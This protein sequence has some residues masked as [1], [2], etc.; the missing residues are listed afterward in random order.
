[1]V[2]DD[3]YPDEFILSS[4]DC[5]PS[6]DKNGHYAINWSR[7]RSSLLEYYDLLCFIN[8]K[9]KLAKIKFPRLLGLNK[10]IILDKLKVLS[11]AQK[12]GLLYLILDDNKDKNEQ[13][14]LFFNKNDV[15][16]L[17][18][19]HEIWIDFSIKKGIYK[20][21]K[22]LRSVS[23]TTSGSGRLFNNET[24]YEYC[25]SFGVH[26]L[27]MGYLFGFHRLAIKGRIL[28]FYIQKIYYTRIEKKLSKAE[29]YDM[30]YIIKEF[31]KNK[32]E[33]KEFEKYYNC[34]INKAR[35]F[36]NKFKKKYTKKFESHWIDKFNENIN[37]IRWKYDLNEVIDDYVP[38]NFDKEYLKNELKKFNKKI[39]AG[40][41]K[42]I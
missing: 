41:I 15:F 19:Y 32:D 16:R 42:H 5:L 40:Y 26:H 18:L 30:K 1:M 6:T 25:I 13:F 37:N 34:I 35:E 2:L 8:G 20:S 11:L 12:K 28:R 24:M 17:I 38:S 36:L 3:I 29:L 10:E 31:N 4:S 21:K 7:F 9:R 33:K 23:K 22:D 39:G 14:L 27:L